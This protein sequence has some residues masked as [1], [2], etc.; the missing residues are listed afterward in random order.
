MAV[1]PET[2]FRKRVDQKL[3]TIPNSYFE[4]IQQRAIR[5]SAD[6]IGCINGRFVWI[7]FK[8]DEKT[9]PME[10]QKLKAKMVD[11]AGGLV[12][13]VYPENWEQVFH[14]LMDLGRGGK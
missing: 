10:L 4:S 14:K 2:R 1:K 11:K 9:E 3:K 7:E 13:V 8:K 6:K 5:G 12:F